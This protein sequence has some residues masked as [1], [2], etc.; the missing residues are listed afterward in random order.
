[1]KT[2]DSSSICICHR[3]LLCMS[4]FC[5]GLV[6]ISNGQES[7]P[8]AR[9]DGQ[10]AGDTEKGFKIRI[11]V[12]EVRLDTVVL[13]KKG[14]QITD[15]TADDFEIYQDHFRQKVTSCTYINDYQPRLQKTIVPSKDSVRLP[16]IPAPALIREN[17]RR[18]IVFV[19][20]NLTMDFTQVH[21]ARR[22]LRKFVEA[23]MQEG[24]LVAIVPTAGANA[25]FQTFSSDKRQL[26]SIIGS[27]R[28]FIDVRTTQMTPQMMAMAYSIRTL[29][30]M[31][32]RKALIII[33]PAM[34]IR[35]PLITRIGPGLGNLQGAVE[36]TEASFNPL[37][38][39][40]LRA[41]VVIHTLDINGLGFGLDVDAEQG[42]DYGLLDSSG[43]LDPEKIQA[44]STRA[45][46]ER[47]SQIQVPLS[48]K[49]GGLFIRDFNWFVDGIGPVQE[50]LKGYYMLTYS[51]PSSTFRKES[52]SIYHR[53]QVK[54]KR[55]GSEVHARDGFYGVAEPTEAPSGISNSLYTAIFSP[56]QHN[57]LKISLASG[58]IDDPPKGYLLQ[59]S[60]H[61][62]AQDLSI[63]EGKE[64]KRF[65]A[66]EAAS[67]TSDANNFIKDS[68]ARKYT[69]DFNKE[70]IP[71]IREHGIKFSLKLPIKKP[72]SYYVRTAVRD[73][74]SGKMGSAYQ[75]I[76]I[77][78]L[79]R[80]RLSLSNIFIINRTEDLPWI[81]SKLPEEFRTLLYPD[82]R[83]DPRKSPA[84]RSYFPG[85]N[86]ECTALIYNAKAK[87]GQKPDLELQY[88]L[89][90]NGR[91]LFKSA[92]ET[93]D[94]SN[95]SDFKRIPIKIKLRLVDSIQPGEYILQMQVRDKQAKKD[96]DLA[97]QML[98][99][100]VLAN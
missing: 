71:W 81:S 72:G 88:I 7:R 78:D 90:G 64:G 19:V 10:Q 9:D 94:L 40:A 12:E 38:D 87:K 23:Q 1:M 2:G 98:D 13:D 33:S 37:A 52:W 80:K 61:L 47:D 70:D 25:T 67:V 86:F 29:Q 99:F 79:S 34:M 84:L 68:N 76:E 62:N 66:V 56:F 89:Y 57:D 75:Y 11:G 31:P 35:A 65:I 77:P 28:Y 16:P 45:V 18:T 6:L 92:I 8:S 26:L 95:V 27:V 5:L 3:T 22:A 83:R 97:A 60:M 58:Y 14:H 93:V 20:D 51:P 43:Q 48:K 41:G 32:G 82:V 46:A 15:L 39:L 91:E 59:S 4:V 96:R 53:I 63:T 85:E 30:D 69:F 21:H 17:V 100:K 55:P 42:F 73:P 36:Y 24:D 50:E 54:A 44:K 49:T 74:V